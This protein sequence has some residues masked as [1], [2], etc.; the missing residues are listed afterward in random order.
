MTINIDTLKVIESTKTFELIIVEGPDNVKNEALSMYKY[1]PG[2]PLEPLV[3][4]L[5]SSVRPK[6]NGELVRLIIA[7]HLV[8]SPHIIS[9][10]LEFMNGLKGS[11]LSV[12]DGRFSLKILL[13]VKKR[14]AELREVTLAHRIDN[15]YEMLNHLDKTFNAITD[16]ADH[17]LEINKTLPEVFSN[18]N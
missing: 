3:T 10:D 16:I 2:F 18:Y 15:H 7:L 11:Y 8:K 5:N 14:E 4:A 17:A 1:L 13:G 12:Y 9:R 6:L